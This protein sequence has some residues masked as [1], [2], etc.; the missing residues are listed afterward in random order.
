MLPIR[1][2]AR[3]PCRIP[4]SGEEK[5]RDSLQTGNRRRVHLGSEPP[6]NNGSTRSSFHNQLA[7][8]GECWSRDPRRLLIMHPAVSSRF[9]QIPRTQYAERHWYTAVGTAL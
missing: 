5:C 3:S 6:S 2:T 7:P 4:P 9:Q 1:D 8:E